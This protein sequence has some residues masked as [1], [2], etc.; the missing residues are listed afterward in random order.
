VSFVVESVFVS[1]QPEI[2]SKA[3]TSIFRVAP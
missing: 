1:Y 3:A 2:N